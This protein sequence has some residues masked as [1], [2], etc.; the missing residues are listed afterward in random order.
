MMGVIIDYLANL[1]VRYLEILR[2][3]RR[4]SR[5]RRRRRSSLLCAIVVEKDEFFIEKRDGQTITGIRD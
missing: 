5:S 2:A 3:K 1:S 4:R